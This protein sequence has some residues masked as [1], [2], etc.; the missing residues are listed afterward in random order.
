[1]LIATED[2]DV[3]KV[4]I[5]LKDATAET[6]NCVYSVSFSNHIYWFQYAPPQLI[7]SYRTTEQKDQV[8]PLIAACGAGQTENVLALLAHPDI[9]I[10]SKKQVQLDVV[11]L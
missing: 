4:Q 8:T 5:L 1:M 7:Q 9:N 2:N 3:A 10:N 11:S 6:V